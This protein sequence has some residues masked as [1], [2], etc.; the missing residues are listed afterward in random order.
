MVTWC[1]AKVNAT[2]C[3]WKA[4]VKAVKSHHSLKKAGTNVFKKRER[5][6]PR[7][8]ERRRKNHE[9]VV[10]LWR[11]AC[12]LGRPGPLKN[13]EK[14]FMCSKRTQEAKT[15]KTQSASKKFDR[16]ICNMK[17]DQS[18]FWE[19]RRLKNIEKKNLEFI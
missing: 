3:S 6:S 9:T 18:V 19:E 17:E 4:R 11:S 16:T 2:I 12:W 15:Q 14:F 5:G 1:G 10:E 7:K 8:K 13:K